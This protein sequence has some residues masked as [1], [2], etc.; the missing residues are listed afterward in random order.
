MFNIEYNIHN[1]DN[2]II[3]THPFNIQK[4]D[5]TN[6]PTFS[7]SIIYISDKNGYYN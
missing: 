3:V 4:K 7:L 5:Q 1:S 2:K 6:Y